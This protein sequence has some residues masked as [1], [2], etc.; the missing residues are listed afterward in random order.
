MTINEMFD[1]GFSPEQLMGLGAKLGADVPFFIL[2]KTAWATGIGTDL[3][4]VDPFP[5]LHLVL[6]NPD[7]EI[8]TKMVYENLNLRLT[9]EPINYSIPRF[10]DVPG[11]VAGLN[12]DLER[13]TL[14]LY[15]VLRHIKKV[16]I[17]HGA[18][19]SLM[20]GSG[21]TVF[22]VFDKEETAI[23]AQNDLIKMGT[24]SVFR[25]SSI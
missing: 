4:A 8:S 3:Q 12:N 25:S 15:P 1:L 2:Q 6:I 23:K 24:W 11:I 20:S 16:L 10:Y 18:K 9:K 21:P 19:G 5:S 13:V 7:F 14:K 22:G 17:D